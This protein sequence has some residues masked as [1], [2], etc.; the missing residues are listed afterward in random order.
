MKKLY[1]LFAIGFISFFSY[2]QEANYCDWEYIVTANNATIAIQVTNSNNMLIQ[3]EDYSALLNNVTCS[4]LIGV[5]YL[6]DNGEYACGGYTEWDGSQS[7]AIAAWGDDPTTTEKDGFSEGEPYVFK[8]CIDPIGTLISDSPNMS[9]ELPFSDSYITNGFGSIN[10]ALFIPDLIT[11]DAGAPI[12][13]PSIDL[14]EK[15]L[16]QKHIVKTVDIT[17]RSIMKNYNGIVFDIYSD[18]TVSKRYKIKY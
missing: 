3:V 16:L 5:F 2:S 18:N 10:T 17:G 14:I 7:M 12:C 1:I 11:L 15:D 4:M 6:D 13:F 8:I 9:T